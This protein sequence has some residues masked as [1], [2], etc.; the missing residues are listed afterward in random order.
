MAG[1]AFLG[2]GDGRS[3]S[4]GADRALVKVEADATGDAFSLIE[5]EAA[6][7]VPGPPPHVH[8]IV[9]ETFY[10]LEGEVDFLAAG[11]KKK[12][13]R[14]SVAFVLPGVPH[15]FANV[16]STPARW[17]GIFSPGRYVDLVEGIG[18]L[19]PPDGPPEEQKIVALGAEYDTEIVPEA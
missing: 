5:Y 19:L 10:V 14:G 13:V 17:V 11:K 3:F 9:S 6:P 15:T 8:R 16:G 12:L 1:E 7:G 4:V 2:P 18:K